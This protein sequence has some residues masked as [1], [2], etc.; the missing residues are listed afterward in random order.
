MKRA[1]SALLLIVIAGFFP[2]A[3]P[4]AQDGCPQ[5]QYQASPPGVPGA[6]FCAPIPRNLQGRAVDPPQPAT[7][8][9]AIATGANHALFGT[10]RDRP[11]K[12]AAEQ[13]AL[14]QCRRHGG[15]ECRIA[16]AYGNG[17]AALA[18]SDMGFQAAA[19]VTLN[20]AR[21]TAMRSCTKTGGVGCH[22]AYSDCSP[23]Q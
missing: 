14:S 15:S 17:C 10:A 9:G 4:H 21:Q 2:T 8:W 20:H 7:H 3:A 11:N 22:V 5:G 16:I 23:A 18:S 19:D 12:A 1:L 13:Q 6:G